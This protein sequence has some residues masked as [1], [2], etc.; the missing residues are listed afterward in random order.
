ME[1]VAP[2]RACHLKRAV[3]FGEWLCAEVLKYLADY[4]III[5][6][7]IIIAFSVLAGYNRII[8]SQIV[9]KGR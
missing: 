4:I 3:E 5:I 2:G 7:Q 9:K 6:S 1:L 8:I